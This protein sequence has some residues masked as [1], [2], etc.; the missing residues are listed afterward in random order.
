MRYSPLLEQLMQ[1]LRCLPTVGQKTAQR[2][3]LHLL[4]RNRE[5]AKHLSHCLLNAMEKI[6]HC[7]SCRLFSETSLC[8]I[9]ANP[10]RNAEQI[11]VVENP[12][13][14]FALEQ[15]GYYHGVYFVLY[16]HLSP[17]DGI[18]PKELGLMA[19]Q[20]RL[21][22]H[23]IQELILGT[24]ATVEGEATAHYLSELAKK[25]NIRVTRLAY[26]I[27]VG[28]DLEFLDPRTLERALAKRDVIDY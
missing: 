15:A 19:L 18:G 17:L 4:T 2:M 9:C 27:P 10:K 7:Q 3:A 13:D 14:V 6:Q 5:Q 22:S 25:S 23:P 20:E 24:S 28:G 26:G 11:C 1:A 21:T 16:G 12:S 8:P